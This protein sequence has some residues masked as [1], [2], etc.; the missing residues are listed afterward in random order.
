MGW[1]P[2]LAVTYI[3]VVILPFGLFLCFA[4]A[5]FL[6]ETHGVNIGSTFSSF[7]PGKP[8]DSMVFV[9]PCNSLISINTHGHYKFILY[10]MHSLCQALLDTDEFGIIFKN[11]TLVAPH[12][13]WVKLVP[14]G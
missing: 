7:L 14:L 1:S 4:G 13:I 5:Q 6:Y 8:W 9:D 10:H 3:S 12:C 2:E 11:S